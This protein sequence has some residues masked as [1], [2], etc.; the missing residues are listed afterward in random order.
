MKFPSPTRPS[1][2]PQCSRAAGRSPDS[3]R[4]FTW[5]RLQTVALRHGWP[6]ES[7][8]VELQ[9]GR[10]NTKGSSPGAAAASSQVAARRG[11]WLAMG[12][13]LQRGTGSDPSI[14]ARAPPLA[15]DTATLCLRQPHAPDLPLAGSIRLGCRAS[16]PRAEASS[17]PRHLP[18]KAT[19]WPLPLRRPIVS[20]PATP[21]PNCPCHP[22]PILPP[23][24][25]RR[26]PIP[27]R[28]PARDLPDLTFSPQTA[29]K[30]AIRATCPPHPSQHRGRAQN[31]ACGTIT[32]PPVS[33]Y[34]SPWSPGPVS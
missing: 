18:L 21:P 17:P 12:P 32:R 19:P 13:V 22:S 15:R 29:R 30:P 16:G 3:G 25:R 1:V 7:Q 4:A 28:A 33:D 27:I 10:T 8:R 6:A 23:H 26:I 20:F 11:A 24:N 14:R 2:V 5:E 9:P 31:L 34:R